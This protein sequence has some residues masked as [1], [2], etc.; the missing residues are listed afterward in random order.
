M[1]LNLLLEFYLLFAAFMVRNC[2][3]D[4]GVLT[5]T[6]HKENDIEKQP[7]VSFLDDLNE[8]KVLIRITINK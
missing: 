2:L 1:F 8:N 3:V 7:A 5:I 6:L 4:C